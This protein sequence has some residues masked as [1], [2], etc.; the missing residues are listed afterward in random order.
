MYRA[1]VPYPERYYQNTRSL[2]L[3]ITNGL[4]LVANKDR[5]KEFEQYL[6]SGEPGG[7]G[8]MGS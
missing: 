1:N 6:T 5:Y 8:G 3:E 7:E 2:I 4:I